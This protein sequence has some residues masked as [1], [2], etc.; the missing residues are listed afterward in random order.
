MKRTNWEINRSPNLI[1][2]SAQRHTFYSLWSIAMTTRQQFIFSLNLDL[3][4]TANRGQLSLMRLH[5]VNK[6][7]NNRWGP[8]ALSSVYLTVPDGRERR[9]IKR[10]KF[11][12]VSFLRVT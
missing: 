9:N 6:K 5:T 4:L 12:Q 8:W 3:G 2:M 7:A 1:N 10:A 11:V